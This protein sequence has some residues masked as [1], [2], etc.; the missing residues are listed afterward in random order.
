MYGEGAAE[1]GKAAF[2]AQLGT[3]F[4]LGQPGADEQVGAE[5]SPYGLE[6]DVSYGYLGADALI[7][8]A[9]AAPPGWRGRARCCAPPSAWRSWPGSTPAL[10]VRL[11][12]MH[13]TG[14][15]F[16]MAFQAGGPHAQDRGLEAVA[17]AYAEQTRLPAKADWTKPQGKR[18]P[19]RMAKE[20]LVP[21]AAS[22]C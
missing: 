22:R 2:D 9:T 15:A 12:V 8:A 20:F 17:C 4:A 3:T 14:Q 11:A 16:G 21:R 5:V 18:D 6:L 7:A 13:T 10:R 19:L 1:A